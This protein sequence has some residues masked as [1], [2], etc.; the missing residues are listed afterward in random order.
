MN[1]V[2][3]IISEVTGIRSTVRERIGKVTQP[4]ATP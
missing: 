4:W 1:N 2:I 3:K